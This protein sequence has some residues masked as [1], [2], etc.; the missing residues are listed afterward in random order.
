VAK[1]VVLALTSDLLDVLLPLLGGTKSD[2]LDF[3]GETILPQGTKNCQSGKIFRQLFRETVLR[4]H[5]PQAVSV[6]PNFSEEQVVFSHLFKRTT[7]MRG[8]LQMLM[9]SIM[10]DL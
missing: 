2:F 3:L 9:E 4:G 7:Q 10:P 1:K 8:L 5:G 6:P